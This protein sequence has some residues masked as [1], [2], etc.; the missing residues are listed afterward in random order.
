MPINYIANQFSNTIQA[1][2]DNG[3]EFFTTPIY[4]NCPDIGLVGSTNLLKADSF[5]TDI[6]LGNLTS[7]TLIGT[8]PDLIFQADQAITFVA[9][10]SMTT[11]GETTTN[12]M[13]GYEYDLPATDIP[14]GT[15][16]IEVMYNGE[17]IRTILVEAQGND[18]GSD[19]SGTDES[20]SSGSGES[21]A[22]ITRF[23]PGFVAIVLFATYMVV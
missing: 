23:M 10:P 21:S 14:D 15:T 8:S 1:T 18:V 2:A 9:T 3:F 11:V 17:S 20:G 19:S 7:F 6:M 16:E 5:E 22:S 4:V 12:L 13:G